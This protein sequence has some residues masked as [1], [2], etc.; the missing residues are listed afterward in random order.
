[1]PNFLRTH[2]EASLARI[3]FA[4]EKGLNILSTAVLNELKDAW[5]E[6]EKAAVR[7]CIISGEGKAFLAGADIKEMSALD[8]EGAGALSTLGQSVFA[9]IEQ[10]NIVSIAAIHG[11]C[12]G[13]GCELALACDIRVGSAGMLIGQP[14]VNLG[15]IPGFGGS[16]RLPRVVGQ[17]MALQMILSGLPLNADDALRCSL[18]TSTGSADDLHS[19]VESLAQTL[20]TRGP[21]ALRLAKKLAH[22]ALNVDQSLGLKAER[23]AFASTFENK[24]AQEGIA[25]FLEK[26]APN[27]K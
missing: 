18:I 8:G 19:R 16:Q 27:F 3:T 25:A 21:E 6:V 10:S 11:A 15:L 7:I 14:E 4:R 24:E 17:G 22:A 13:G 9:K 1:M 23:Y 2:I 20:L 26:R 12:L 5:D